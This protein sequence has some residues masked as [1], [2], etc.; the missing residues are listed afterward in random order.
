MPDALATLE[1]ERSQILEQFLSLSDS[2]DP[3]RS[4]LLSGAVGNHPAIAPNL[5][6]PGHDPQ[7]RRT[8]RIHAHCWCVSTT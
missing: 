5:T 3:I 1:A 6:T 2:C 4:P 7:F 8:F